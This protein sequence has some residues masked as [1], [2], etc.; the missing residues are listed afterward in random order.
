M[1]RLSLVML[2]LLVPP[3]WADDVLDQVRAILQ[4]EPIA[5]GHFRQT[6]QLAFLQQPLVSEGE[7]VYAQ[8]G[9]VI[10]NTVSPVASTVLIG[11]DRMVSEQGE[12]A[13]PP[14]F[15][16]LIPALLGGDFAR[17]RTD[18]EI[19]GSVQARSWR[20]QFLPK[21]PLLAK[22]VAEL[23]LSGD[24]DLRGFDILESGG[25]RSSTVFEQISHPAQLTPAQAA[26]FERLS[27]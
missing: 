6:K 7:F 23:V 17:L 1:F 5:V 18:F 3:A 27:P 11:G 16:Q 14:S 10:W 24:S 12:Q 19:Q 2:M 15:G 8:S 20:L 25:N 9:G 21:D 26:E 4:P 13:L 22:I